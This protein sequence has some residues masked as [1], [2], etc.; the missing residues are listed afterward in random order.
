MRQLL[1]FLAAAVAVCPA[2][3]PKPPWAGSPAKKSPA[4]EGSN[5]DN[6][7]QNPNS[8]FKVDVKLVNVFVT[9][10]DDHGA[11]VGGLTK[12]NFTLL[13]DGTPQTISV[14]DK[15]SALPLSIVM[16]IDTSLSTRKDLPLELTSARR[17]AHAILRPV[18]ALCLYEFS[19]TVD[20]IVPFT[21]DLKA[22]DRGIDRV[23]Y[24]AAT[25]LYDAIY[26]G[27]QAVE[28]RQGRKVMVIITDGGDTVSRVDYKEAVRA[29]QEAEVIVYSIIVVPIEASAGRDL[30]GE[31]ALIQI[32]A[33]TGGKYFYA[34]SVPQLDE[35]FHKIS[36]ELRT[37]Y[38]LAYYPSRRTSDSNYRRI[39][40]KVTSTAA[41]S[42]F[43]V[44]HRT[45]YYTR[46]SQF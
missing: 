36:D 4:V 32:S 31:H 24:G 26:L 20:E 12:D 6:A 9:V 7:A 3:V 40:V 21:P 19:E 42:A 25:A 39:E 41:G 46:K 5:S 15:E 28:R 2:Q 29:A 35:A 38:L 17:F 30:G 16:D 45:G 34:T 10:T 23:H 18:D 44:H 27:S 22:I 11:P 1:I 8:T 43:E 37:Q 33:D 14:F 13:E